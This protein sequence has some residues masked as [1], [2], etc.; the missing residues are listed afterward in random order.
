VVSTS[1]VNLDTNLDITLPAAANDYIQVGIDGVWDNGSPIAH[2]NVS[3]VASGTHFAPA[4]GSDAGFCGASGFGGDF[5]P[6]NI[7]YSR[8]L[9]AGDISGGNVQ[10][11][12]RGRI[13]SAGSRALLATSTDPLT[14]FAFNL[15]PAV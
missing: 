7:V 1:W 3:C 15:G 6:F 14:F 12:L 11:R 8:Q 4:G 10:V 2:V 13:E 5:R 9:V